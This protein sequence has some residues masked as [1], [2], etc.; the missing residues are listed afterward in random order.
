MDNRQ[1][2]AVSRILK[3]DAQ[4]SLTLPPDV[5]GEARPGARYVVETHGDRVL[6]R[7]QRGEQTL[8]R[9]LSWDE[10]WEHWR[11]LSDAVTR[12]STTDESAVE[13]LSDMRR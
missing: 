12:A 10:W 11:T 2:G 6:L 8:R 3:T 5:L 1:E 13:I 7:P 9:V 4:G